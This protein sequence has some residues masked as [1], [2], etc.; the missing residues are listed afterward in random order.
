MR[1]VSSFE[2]VQNKQGQVCA[3]GG[4]TLQPGR[5]VELFL[6]ICT[7]TA[8]PDEPGISN[9]LQHKK[10][11]TYPTERALRDA[12]FT[13]L[14][15]AG[16]VVVD[17]QYGHAGNLDFLAACLGEG[18]PVPRSTIM[19]GKI[20]GLSY[21]DQMTGATAVGLEKYR[22]QF[23]R[24]KMSAGEDAQFTL[25]TPVALGWAD[26]PIPEHLLLRAEC[27]AR[28]ARTQLEKLED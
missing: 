9:I 1:H 14:Q 16:L 12:F 18:K 11:T 26:R 23:Y 5:K 17:G 15:T 24:D 4:F 22:Q 2:V 21:L 7:G 3:V 28:F 13:W 19:M 6:A 10:R 27:L 20:Q 8:D 25:G